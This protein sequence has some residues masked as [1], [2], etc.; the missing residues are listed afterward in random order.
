MPKLLS[1]FSYVM[2]YMRVKRF[3]SKH[4]LFLASALVAVSL[5]SCDLLASIIDDIN[6]AGNQ[7]A[8]NQAERLSEGEG[9]YTS[10]SVLPTSL[11][12]IGESEYMA[13]LPAEGTTRLLV[14]PIEFTDSP[15]S[16]RTLKDLEIA[17]GGTAEET[18]YW[19]SVSS[20][21]AKSSF[22]KVNLVYEMADVYN[23]GL[24][25]RELY[26]QSVR[27]KGSSY[28][29]D[30]GVGIIKKAFDAYKAKKEESEPTYLKDHFDADKNGW[31]D[32]IV[33]VYSGLDKQTGR[34]N[35]DQAAYYWAY[36]YWAVGAESGS[37]TWTS[38]NKES[39]TPNLYFWLS[40]NFIYEA[41]KSPKS[42]SHT[43]IHETGHM[44]GL[45]D[46][47]PDTGSSF[48]AAGCWSMM[49][50]NILDHDVFSKMILGWCN[51]IIADGT[52]EVEI[53]PAPS[54]GDCILFPTGNWNGTAYDEYMLLEY[55]TPTDLNYLDSHTQYP[56][57]HRGYSIP[58][59]KIYHIDARLV[60]REKQRALNYSYV[61]DPNT[62]VDKAVI[63]S[64]TGYRI[65]ATN[66]QKESLR[67]DD[68]F[69]LIHLMEAT[70]VNTFQYNG[71]GG[72]DTLFLKGSTFSFAK[73][74]LRFFPKKST[75]NN[76]SSF[77]FTIHVK[78]IASGKATIAFEKF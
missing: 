29:S 34:L 42:D 10:S 33:A 67:C 53:N 76:G 73:F 17:L 74:G 7:N 36:T 66:C 28:V 24:T 70:G 2:Y 59:I 40:Y 30:N 35:Y 58:G 52:G 63:G 50:Q 8:S 55:Y 16:Q 18:G 27:R 72:N 22:G 48:N 57:R 78:D 62:I 14:L 12:K 1:T 5:S 49:D 32:G 3:F 65:A 21:Y 13:Y 47:Y 68:S 39:P 61:K 41:V 54:S 20:F 44:F 45:D 46:Y 38:P 64:T 43:L 56:N 60:E 75:M 77:N 31:I 9:W 11:A 19:E 51:P 71:Y 26:D 69:S 4:I 6:S 23:T 15:F 37:L 25:Q